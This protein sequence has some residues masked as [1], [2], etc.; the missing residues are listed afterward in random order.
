[1][2]AS[3]LLYVATEVDQARGTAR[4]RHARGALH[5][6]DAAASLNEYATYYVSCYT[7]IP[8]NAKWPHV[9]VFGDLGQVLARMRIYDRLQKCSVECVKNA[10]AISNFDSTLLIALYRA[11]KTSTGG[12]FALRGILTV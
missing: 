12:Q 8:Y 6:H 11:P 5:T 7:R 4:A 2:A 1:M 10:F 3:W 9:G